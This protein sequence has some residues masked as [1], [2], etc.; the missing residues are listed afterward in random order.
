MAFTIGEIAERSGFTP[1]ALR[2]Y[3]RIG[4]VAPAS[5]SDGGYRLYDDRTLARL[6]FIERAKQLGCSLDDIADLVTIWERDE[7]GPVQKRFHGLVTAKLDA[8]RRQV[9]ELAEFAEQLSAAAG[10][11][12]SPATDGPCGS[13]CACMSG[14]SDESPAVPVV[15]GG[16]APDVPIAC[17]LDRTMLSTRV[18]DWQ[19]LLAT[20]TGRSATPDGGLRIEFGGGVDLGR[21]GQL[22]A[23][24]R[25]CC[26]FFA[27]AIT[28]DGRGVAPR[29]AG[30]GRCDRRR[31]RALR[32]R[33][34][35]PRE[36]TTR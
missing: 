5:R 32:T 18:D 33:G 34:M 23:D 24:E 22:V 2:Y 27:F 10:Q 1:S 17:S 6:E 14:E 11:L 30:S 7:C 28:T 25:N 12:A 3:E 19:S 15:R 4:L 29:G 35:K 8:A 16:A 9:A 20:A 31:R 36:L 21:L 13:G 26:E